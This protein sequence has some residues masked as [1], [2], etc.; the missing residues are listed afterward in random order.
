[1]LCEM[2]FKKMH[3]FNLPR[4]TIPLQFSVSKQYVNRESFLLPSACLPQ[5]NWQWLMTVLWRQVVRSNHRVWQGK[6]PPSCNYLW[7][8]CAAN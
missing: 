6:L 4:G 8:R 3:L 7:S 1:M 2:W 5:C